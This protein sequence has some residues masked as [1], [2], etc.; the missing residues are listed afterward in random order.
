MITSVDS[1]SKNS[2]TY[3]FYS[4]ETSPGG[5][6][7]QTD[8]MQS[9]QSLDI[10]G[11]FDAGIRAFDIKLDYY[12]GDVVVYVAGAPTEVEFTSM[13]DA[14]KAKLDA[15]PTEFVVIGINYVERGD[16]Q[17]WLN[18]ICNTV[19]TWSDKYPRSD[20]EA[21][22]TTLNDGDSDYFREI[23]STTTVGVM[24]HG[25]GLMIHCPSDLGGNPSFRSNHVNII[26]NYGTSVQNV[27]LHELDIQSERGSGHVTLQDLQQMNNPDLDLYPYFITEDHALEGADLN[28]IQTKKNLIEQ[29][30][31]LSRT[32]NATGGSQRVNNLYINDLGGFCVVNSSDGLSTGYAS[33]RIYECESNF[34]GGYSWESQN[35]RD[36]TITSCLDYDYVFGSS[37]DVNVP[38]ASQGNVGQRYLVITDREGSSR[39]EGGNN[40]LLAEQ[41]NP[42]AAD[43]IYNLV[44]EGRTP[45]GVVY[46]NF[47]GEDQVTI[48]GETYNVSGVQLPSLIMSNNFKFALATSAETTS[49]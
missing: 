1:H 26:P 15:A 23:I 13:L 7:R 44:N 12:N 39:G 37:E 48:G 21:D 8:R 32:N 42:F 18:A 43:L 33:G 24:R 49:N 40:A 41:I 16:P 2:Y 36:Q 3:R 11:Q 10:D 47:A 20:K 5:Y 34:W 19:N 9:Y 14:I 25:I 28:L 30:F 27:T 45:L 6:N 29:L 46:M 4:Q 31:T 38:E 22:G 35:R 17:G